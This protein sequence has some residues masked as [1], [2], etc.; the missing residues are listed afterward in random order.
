[1]CK[2]L[3]IKTIYDTSDIAIAR[4]V[5]TFFVTF[6][7]FLID[8]ANFRKLLKSACIGQLMSKAGG[9]TPS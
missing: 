8:A 3:Y 6:N 2:A 5:S 4:I 7:P 9:L 1:V